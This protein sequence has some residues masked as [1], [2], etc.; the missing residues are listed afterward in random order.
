[1]QKKVYQ[2]ECNIEVNNLILNLIF[3]FDYWIYTIK[4]NVIVIYNVKEVNLYRKIYFLLSIR[5]DIIILKVVL[6]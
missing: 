1:M 3:K 6:F 5:Y 2:Y 4:F